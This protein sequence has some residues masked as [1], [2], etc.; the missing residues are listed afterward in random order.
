M[1]STFALLNFIY[2][3]KTIIEF[4]MQVSTTFINGQMYMRDVLLA[5][6]KKI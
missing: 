4:I 6:G 2:S 3:K 1:V 5:A